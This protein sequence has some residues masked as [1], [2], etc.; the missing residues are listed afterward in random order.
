[1]DDTTKQMGF[2]FIVMAKILLLCG[3]CADDAVRTARFA[4]VG[5]DVVARQTIM[6]FDEGM[7]LHN[8]H[9]VDDVTFNTERVELGVDVAELGYD[10]TEAIEVDDLEE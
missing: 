7:D 3:R 5:G 10:I 4:D 2:G 8:I 9:H 1:M 6:H